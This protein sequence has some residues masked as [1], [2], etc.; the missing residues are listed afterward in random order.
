MLKQSFSS[1]WEPSGNRLK[2]SD[3]NEILA[4]ADYCVSECSGLES[5]EKSIV[6]HLSH[7]CQNDFTLKQINTKVEEFWKR[8]KRPNDFDYK[9]VYRIGTKALQGKEFG[10]ER[11]QFVKKRVQHL[12]KQPI[13]EYA[14]PSLR[15]ARKKRKVEHIST[16]EEVPKRIIKQIDG[17][18]LTPST[19]SITR[20]S[21]RYS[22]CVQVRYFDILCIVVARK[23][24]A[25]SSRSHK[26][27]AE[28]LS[29]PIY[30]RI[31]DLNLWFLKVSTMRPHTYQIF[32][33]PVT[34]LK[35][36]NHLLRT[37]VEEAQM[38]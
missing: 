29:A 2:P 28:R 4:W 15:S 35:T 16:R 18:Y 8:N 17:S 32:Q 30:S 23:T 21:P 24:N 27:G 25:G 3:V 26:C 6:A 1:Y 22:I 7:S 20:R 34:K 33:Q 19:R 11:A 5:F 13:P 37:G 10:D 31:F 12:L 36:P 9:I 14:E 38:S